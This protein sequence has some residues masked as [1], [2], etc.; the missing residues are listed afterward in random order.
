MLLCHKTKRNESITENL[1]QLP[2][3][4]NILQGK[5]EELPPPITKK[6]KN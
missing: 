6:Y 3:I 2:T 5:K 1:D 4:G